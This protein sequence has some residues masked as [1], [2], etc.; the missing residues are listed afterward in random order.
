M[1]KQAL[2]VV[3]AALGIVLVTAGGAAARSGAAD[4]IHL[5]TPMTAAQETPSPTGNV[6]D[7]KGTFT[8]TVNKTAGGATLEWRLAFSGLT[9]P[10]IAAHIHLAPRGQ[11]AGVAVPFCAPCTSGA[12]GTANISEA[13]LAAIE[14]GRAYVNVHTRTNTLGEIR[15]QIASVA[16]A[17]TAM[18]SRQEVPRPKGAVRRARGTFTA[19]ARKE[20]A[21]ATLTWKL[22]FSRLTGRA[23]AAHIHLGRRGKAGR[24]AVSLCGPCRSGAG[25][26][27]TVRGGVLA[28]LETG[29]AYVNVHTRRNPGGE[30]RGQIAALALSTS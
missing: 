15:G 18:T 11:A 1:R 14:A 12:S 3:A 4:T 16:S 20:G 30:I 8:A 9:G 26:R 23:I 13:V 29:R 10:A 21:A 19:T 7:A 28:A 6:G 25:G 22:T 5:S 27:A 17:R 2:R 24:I